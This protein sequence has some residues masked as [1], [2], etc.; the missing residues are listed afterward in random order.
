MERK[1]R[2]LVVDDD[3]LFA[4]G[5][6]AFLEMRGY[7]VECCFS[8]RDCVEKALDFHPEAIVSDHVMGDLTGL[9]LL[10]TL[11]G[12]ASSRDVPFI[13]I[14]GFKTRSLQAD[15]EAAGAHVVISKSEASRRLLDI[16]DEIFKPGELAG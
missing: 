9:E 4:E 15:F 7:D 16:L 13:V 6:T 10:R 2:L 3:P 8:G 12:N 11:K 5:V 1:R 14:T